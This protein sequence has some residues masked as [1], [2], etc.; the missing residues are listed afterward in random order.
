MSDS[1]TITLAGESVELMA[2]R[3]LYWPASRALI[4]ADVHL[5]KESIFGR[6]GLAIPDGSTGTDLARLADLVKRCR[7][8]RLIVLGD[9][10]HAPPDPAATWPAAL[11]AWLDAHPALTVQ[12]IAGNHDRPA[13]RRRLDTRIAWT[14]GPLQMSPFVLAHEPL[15][16]G[17]EYVLCGHLHPALRLKVRSDALRSP[18]FWLTRDVG[19]LPSFGRFTGGYNVRP[20]AEDRVFM[21]G[22]GALVEV[23]GASVDRFGAPDRPWTAGP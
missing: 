6:S 15:R 16:T 9:L 11:S 5:G 1:A 20:H 7:A 4:V 12:V 10:V 19:V 14:E 2:E 13:A 22:P 21:T 3:A 18:V 17:N 8:Q 23:S